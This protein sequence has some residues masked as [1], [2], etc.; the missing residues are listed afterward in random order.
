MFELS[1]A[2]EY[3]YKYM[4]DNTDV[5]GYSDANKVFPSLKQKAAGKADA[6]RDALASESK[7]GTVHTHT[8]THTR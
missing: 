1:D 7:Q 5:F 6:L 4:A 2:D 3:T 8:H